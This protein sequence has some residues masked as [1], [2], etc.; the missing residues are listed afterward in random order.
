MCLSDNG[1]ETGFLETEPPESQWAVQWKVTPLHNQVVISSQAMAPRDS[2]SPELSSTRRAPLTFPLLALLAMFPLSGL[3]SQQQ[4]DRYLTGLTIL[5]HKGCPLFIGQVARSSPAEKAGIQP[6]DQLTAVAGTH[7]EDAREAA[8]LLQTN[9]PRNVLL[10]LQRNG[11]EIEVYSGYEK[12]SSIHARNGQ[13]VVSGLVVPTDTSQAEVDRMVA[14]DGQRIVTRVFPT[15]YPAQAEQFYVGFEIFVLRDPKEVQVGGIEGGPAS[16]AGIHWGDVLLSVNGLL[17]GDKTPTELEQM[18]S[19]T[20][21]ATI[22][23]QIKRLDSEKEFRIRLERGED[24]ARR[25]GKRI[26][27]GQV[28]PIWAT[29]ADLHCFLP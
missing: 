3:H 20:T 14:F 22:H 8:R 5:S 10:T 2:K 15:H 17:V 25:N 12:E 26:V 27:D 11:K 29:N 6:G 18:F 28:V 7:V 9:S 21:P 24:I 1:F 13:R 4:A 23:I 16:D 19:A